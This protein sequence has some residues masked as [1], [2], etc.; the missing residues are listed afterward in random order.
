MDEFMEKNLKRWN[1]TT[2]MHAKSKEYDLEGFIKGRN[3]L[4]PIELKAL[5]DVSGKTLLHLQCQFGMDT[6]SWARLGAKVTGIDFSDVAIDLANSINEKLKLPAKFICTNIYDL[7]EDLDEQF[8]VVFTS[9]GVLT[10]LPDIKK[11]AEIVSK[12]LK[13]GGMFLIVE[14]H[15]FTGVFDDEHPSELVYKYPYF[16]TK[17]PM[18]F[19]SEYT[20]T[21]SEKL[22]ENV[23]MYEWQHSF[24]DIINSLINAGLTILQVEEYPYTCFQQFPF[25]KKCEDG[26]WRIEDD[27][28]E[29][30]LM[31]SIKATKK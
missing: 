31:F 2:Q 30:P 22:V 21:D 20:Y 15:P 3:S 16:Y 27:K 26:F 18:H 12:Y 28:Y 14:I 25:S 8:D 23:D 1:E 10:W 24:S 7:P 4:Y 13:P 17:N 5:G 11:W 9:Y 19:K 29:I 6:L